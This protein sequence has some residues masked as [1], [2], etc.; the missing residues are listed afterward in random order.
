MRLANP[1][2]VDRTRVV[3][4]QWDD[5]WMSGFAGDT[6]AS[7]LMANDVRLVGRSFKYHRP[8]GLW[9]AGSEEP[10]ALVGVGKGARHVPNARATQVELYDGLYALSQNRWPSLRWDAMEVNDL[11]ARFLS[12]G[13]YYKT[14]MWPRSF[15]ER[16]YEP[17]IRRAAGLGKLSGRHNTET[18]EKAFASCDV[19]VIGAGPAGLVAA[20]TAARS[21]ADVILADEDTRPGGRLLASDEQI[22][23]MPAPE[24]AA[25]TCAELEETGRV[26]Y[27]CRTTV[28]GAYDGGT[29]GALERVGLH[30]A[31]PPEELPRECFWRIAAKRSVLC[32]GASERPIA[33]AQNDRPGIM[34]AAAL[35]A[36]ALRWGVAPGPLVALFGCHD[37]MYATAGRL[38]A[39]GVEVAALIDTRQDAPT[40]DGAPVFTSAQVTGTRGRY[41]L[42]K[43]IVTH[44]TGVAEVDVQALGVSGGWT[45]NVQ[46]SCHLDASPVWDDT[47]HAFLPKPGA[48]PGMLAAGAAAGQFS[49]HG[50][51]ASGVAQARAAVEGIGFKAR[52]MQVPAAEDMPYRITPVYHVPGPGRAWLDLQNDVTV[53]DVHLAASENMRA[54]EHMKR[55][56]TQGMAPDQ[57][58]SS[59]VLAMAVL[60][61]ATGRSLAETGTTRF[62]PPFTPVSIAAIGAGAQGAG[63]APARRTPSHDHARACG[64]PLLEAGLWHRPAYYPQHG[65]KSWR[66]AC[67]REVAF[68]RQA[69]GVCDVSTLGKIAVEG[70]DAAAFLDFV[71]AGRMSSLKPGRVRYGLM[72]REDGIV[73]DDGT[74]ACLEPGK[75]L[76][77]T[78]TA[79]AAQV[80]QHL[81]F[82]QQVLCPSLRVRF[83]SVTDHWAQVAVAGPKARDLLRSVVDTPDVVDE[84][85][86]LGTAPVAVG[87]GAA[88]LYRISFSGEMGFELAV[89]AAR[90]A[91]LHAGMATRAEAAGGGVY[92]M[93][94]LNVLR[95][96][97]GFVTHAEIDGRVT[98]GDLGLGGLVKKEGDFIGKT[99]LA[100]PGLQDKHRPRLVGLQ[101]SE[102]S[103]GPSAGAHLFPMGAEAVRQNSEG[104]VSSA[105]YSPTVGHG[106]ALAFLKDGAARLGTQIMAV[107]HVRKKTVRCTVTPVC[108]VDPDGGRMRA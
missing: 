35:E 42:R 48:V 108:P 49:T 57:G 89:P 31:A 30:L 51:L 37:G 96:E 36:Y 28:S 62:R 39:A 5:R 105:C 12:A 18:Y 65:D 52:D 41:G 11:A 50:A 46:L 32:S 70:P 61:D 81:E 75:Y 106:L 4:F 64:A 82:V 17:A 90:G 103:E 94:A 73:M 60:A 54:V 34:S 8:R 68:V 98:P 55:Y 80:M 14:F 7:A 21:G 79:A 92:G 77:T 102:A 63:F 72:L 100:R 9:G 58:R 95:I 25:R 53:K 13:F 86:F 40:F 29:Y 104:H 67:D 66:D 3:K 87:G 44:A 76:V 33:F 47:L 101:P 78:T 107:D 10:N 20:L 56:T 69:V 71:Y 6:L 16:L 85:T 74:C 43:I 83:V 45:P 26:R 93:E 1:G 19:L 2:E 27:M 22:D 91:E 24:W 59:N 99:A 88:R 15:W 97:K 23:G 84:I 38:R